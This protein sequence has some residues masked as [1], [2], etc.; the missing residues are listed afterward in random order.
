MKF[1]GARLVCAGYPADGFPKD[2][3]G[4][5]R[6]VKKISLSLKAREKDRSSLWSC[7]VGFV[8]KRGFVIMTNPAVWLAVRFA[9]ALSNGE[10][11]GAVL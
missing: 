4:G 11:H 6:S 8:N 5:V 7:I 2:R 3:S 9:E 1:A 10:C